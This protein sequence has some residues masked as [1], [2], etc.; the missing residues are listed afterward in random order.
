MFINNLIDSEWRKCGNVKVYSQGPGVFVLD[1]ESARG[2]E[3]AL[4][5]Q[6]PRFYDGSKP[7]ILKPWSRDMSLEIKE[8]KTAPIWIKLPNLRLHL[9]S[10]EALSK[11][12]SLVGRPLFAD[13]VTASRETL[14]FARVCVEVDFDKMLP[15]S[16]T[17]EDDKGYRYDQKVE[18]E[19]KP[20]SRCSYCLHLVHSDS[21]P[22]HKTTFPCPCCKKYGR[23]CCQRSC[24]PPRFLFGTAQGAANTSSTTGFGSAAAM[25]GGEAPVCGA[26]FSSTPAFGSTPAMSTPAFSFS[27]T[28]AFSTPAMSGGEAP[29]CGASFSST[30]A[31]GSTPAPTFGSNLFSA[32]APGADSPYC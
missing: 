23:F 20:T 8:L 21:C 27:S 29:V 5:S 25:S 24:G 4:G 11:I 32:T 19:W 15:D 9:W 12:V 13:T 31:F 26:S 16:V 7:F 28:P 14:C 10:P 17:I 18:Y 6:G 2:K 30:P 3:L 1:F 22:R